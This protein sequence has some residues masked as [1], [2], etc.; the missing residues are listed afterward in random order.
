MSTSHKEFK[1]PRLIQREEVVDSERLFRLCFGVSEIENEDEIRASYAT[2]RRGG[3]YA[4]LH[5]GRPV[6]QIS[7]F[8]DQI[9]IYDGVV[10]TGS[11]GGVC[12]HPDYRE[13]GLAGRLLEHCAAAVEEGR[14]NA[15]AC[16]RRPW[17]LYVCRKCIPWQI[18]L[19]YN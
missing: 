10:H 7:I 17:G 19:L 5:E 3:T 18:H 4:F 16:F 2:P 15:H 13:Q 8:H 6:S 9:K 1:G 11:I 14:C 12:T